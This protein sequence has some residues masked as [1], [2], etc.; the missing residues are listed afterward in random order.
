M[1]FYSEDFFFAYVGHFFGS[2]GL[3][4]SLSSDRPFNGYILSFF[5]YFLKDNIFLWHISTFLIRL[6]GGYAL[7]FLLFKIWPNKL[8]ITTLI[9]MLFL[10]YPGFLQQPL[11]LGYQIH[12]I[13]MTFWITS[14]LFTVLA[15]KS[16]HLFKLI[17]YSL[18]ALGLQ[19]ITF[20]NLE[21][22]IGLELFRILIITLILRNKVSFLEIRR[23]FP[24]WSPYILTTILFILWR[25]VIF[26]S[27]RPETDINFLIQ[28][29]YSSPFWLLKILLEIIL[30]FLHTI[31]FA[32]FLP[33]AINFIRLPLWNSLVS[34]IIGFGSATLILNYLKKIKIENQKQKLTRYIFLIGLISVIGILLPIMLSGRFI[35][36]YSVYDRYTLVTSI[37][38][39]FFI[40][41]LLLSKFAKKARII[42]FLIVALSLTSHLMNGFYRVDYWNKQ[43][44][45]WWQLY[46]RAPKIEDNAMLILDFPKVTED[47]PFKEIINKLKWY[48]F[49]WAEEQ[50][51][52]TGNLFFNYNNLPESHFHGDFLADNNI[53]KKI[54]EGSIE[55]F[56]NRNIVYTRDF[57]KSIIITVPAD[58]SC[59]K[60]LSGDKLIKAEISSLPPKHI[61]GIEP[62]HSWCYFF[63]KASL[64]RQFKDWNQLHN[65]KQEVMSKNLKPKDPSEWLPF[66]ENI[67]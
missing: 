37:A 67:R 65:L 24:Y 12:V 60:I 11:P 4:E 23:T 44:D 64:A 39:T 41:G 47:I 40:T 32:Y 25:L 31:I 57:K 61:F 19:I 29:Y 2:A 30:S 16:Q 8:S 15:I 52:T 62:P 38:V 26:K 18:I 35:R 21:F 14:L 42:I 17:L 49:Y 10:I 46:W 20:L 13:S 27:I 43:K 28:N 51:W 66:E 22:F 59:L 9:T 7:F 54:K 3:M 45:L 34:A 5:F 53:A 63:Q 56:N 33:L 58:V 6:F 48:R 50:I 1:G 55:K 36:V